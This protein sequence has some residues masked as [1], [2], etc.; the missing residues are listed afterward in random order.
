MGMRDLIYDEDI[1][2]YIDS[3]VSFCDNDKPFYLCAIFQSRD[4]YT[5]NIAT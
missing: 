5:P 1:P 4:A 3:L 2:D